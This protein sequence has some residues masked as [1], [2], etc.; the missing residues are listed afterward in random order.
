MSGRGVRRFVAALLAG[1][2]PKPVDIDAAEAAEL[3]AAITLRAARAGSGAPREEFLTDLHRR[4]SAELADPAPAPG[5]PLGRGGS[6]RR[7]LQGA[8]LAAAAAAVGAVLD[9]TLTLS[10]AATPAQADPTLTPTA[11]AWRTVAASAELPEGGI[12]GFDLGSMAGFVHRSQGQL[13]AVSGVCTHQGC[14]LRLDAPAGR[15]DCPCHTTT[16]AISG[17]LLTHQLP[18]APRP[19][20]HLAVREQGG[21]IQIYAPAAPV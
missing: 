6:R 13:R 1:R 7:L 11:G 9:H 14:R 15:L 5:R 4:L 16:F 12:R 21:Q 20:P 17:Q 2:R 19:L 10:R 3:R 8:S 18:V